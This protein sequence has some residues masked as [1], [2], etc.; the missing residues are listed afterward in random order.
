MFHPTLL[1][2][3]IVVKINAG[4]FLVNGTFQKCTYS[5]LFLV[6]FWGFFGNDK[7]GTV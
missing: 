1:L 2:S 6:L 7:I 5:L 4:M 3:N